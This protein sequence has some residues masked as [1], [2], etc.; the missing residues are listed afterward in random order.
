MHSIDSVAAEAVTLHL[1]LFCFA[2]EMFASLRFLGCPCRALGLAGT[3]SRSGGAHGAV[4]YVRGGV[5]N[6]CKA[7][8]DGRTQATG[9]Q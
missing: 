1:L 7:E 6:V 9:G 4:S 8:T 2:D 3:P 5:C